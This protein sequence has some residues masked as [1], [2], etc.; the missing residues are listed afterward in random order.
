MFPLHRSH[1]LFVRPP[2]MIG[3]AAVL[4]TGLATAPASGQSGVIAFR[5]YCNGRLY[6]IRGDGSGRIALPLPQLPQPTAEYRYSDPWI[7]DVTTSDPLTN[8]PVTVVY[9]VGI[10]RVNQNQSTLVD[11]GLFA[12]QLDDVGGV[13][14]C[15]SLCPRMWAFW[16][17]IQT[18][19]G[20]G[21]F[22]SG[23][24]GSCGKRPSCQ[25]ADD[26]QSRSRRQHREDHWP[27]GS[28]RGGRF[29]LVGPSRPHR[30]H[31]ERLHRRRRLL[32]GRKQH[33]CVH[34]LRS[35]AGPSEFRKHEWG[36]RAPYREHRWLRRVETRV[37]AGR[38]SYCLHRRSDCY[39]YGWSVDNGH[40]FASL[41]HACRDAG[42]HE[43]EQGQS[44]FGA[45][46][47]DVAVRR[48]GNRLLGFYVCTRRSS[49]CSTLLN[50]ELFLINADGSN[51]A[52]QITNTNGTSVEAW[53][54]WGW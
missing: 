3:L 21:R 40:L 47:R 42:Y 31:F 33:R 46:Q 27:V 52:V 43:Q 50:S 45:P 26:G 30:A 2:C 23:S 5:D 12:V 16:G 11:S 18:G 54:K 29:V 41:G 22:L 39:L 6:A 8:D 51:S 10:V 17:S 36:G 49:P 14:P 1:Q 13:L 15:G 4:L 35:L 32:S 38:H 9:Y 53:P 20:V 24:A 44:G 28:G 34:P 25:R 19:P 7:V 37:L 48:Y